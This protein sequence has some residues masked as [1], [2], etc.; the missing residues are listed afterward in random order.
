VVAISTGF[1]NTLALVGDGPPALNFTLSKPGLRAGTFSVAAPTRSGRV[2]ALEY[3]DSLADP[4]WSPLPLQAGDGG[5][6]KLTDEAAT[7]S[8][9]FYRLRAR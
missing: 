7:G 8:Q 1:Y 5:T 4:A 6:K 2:Y 9:R 3:K